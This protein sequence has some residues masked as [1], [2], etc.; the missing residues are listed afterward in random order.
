MTK[1]CLMEIPLHCG[2]GGS[3]KLYVIRVEQDGLTYEAVAYNGRRGSTLKRQRPQYSGASLT[4]ATS[5]AYD[6]RDGKTSGSASSSRYS[7][8]TGTVVGLPSGVP[9]LISSSIAAPASTPAAP[10]APPA[11]IETGPEVMLAKPI[12]D[13]EADELLDNS[14]YGAQRKHDGVRVTV[15]ISRVSI[16]GYTGRTRA[17]R[18]LPY[19]VVSQLN[20]LLIL[21]DFSGDRITVLDGEL[22]GT[23]FIAFDVIELRGNDMRSYSCD[24]RYACLELLLQ[25][26]PHMLSTMAYTREE[27]LALVTRAKAENWEGIIYRLLDGNYVPG[28]LGELL[29]HKF[30]ASC[31]ARVT[32][33][34]TKRSI[35]LALRDNDG[36]EI[37]VGN[38]SVPADQDMPA[39]DSL[40]EVRYLYAM[41][42][43]SLYQPILIG[44]RHDLDE[45]DLRSSVKVAPP[46]KMVEAEAA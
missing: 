36:S 31:T 35:K 21:P 41:D 1:A 4:T 30:W 9:P 3:D 40:V 22:V 32:S 24:E 28:R 7:N 38:V 33:I 11:P 23:K 42:G 14:D 6:M 34:N 19:E 8:Y 26:F 13:K 46:E 12:N 27:K 2:T 37:F 5:K 44:V 15:S 45:A 39:L 25:K 18:M 20:E 29:K 16:I 17:V 43:G 10:V